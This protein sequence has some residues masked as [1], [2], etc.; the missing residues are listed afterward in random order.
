M[1]LHPNFIFAH[2]P[3]CGGN[4]LNSFFRDNFTECHVTDKNHKGLLDIDINNRKTFFTIRNPFDWYVSWWAFNKTTGIKEISKFYKSVVKDNYENFVRSILNTKEGKTIWFDFETMTKLD[5]GMLTFKFLRI[6]SNRNITFNLKPNEI[7]KDNIK[8]YL[9]ANDY[10]DINKN[11]NCN[12]YKFFKD[13]NLLH[14]TNEQKSLLLK[15][16]KVNTSKHNHYVTYY[17]SNEVIE[18]IK[19][20]DRLIF[21][22]FKYKFGE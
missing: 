9:L 5:I 16:K 19:H 12:L 8:N 2:I 21:E 22:L 20:K 1:I 18:L 11:F 10:I 7:T 3:K 4:F 17:K 6:I 14:F 15:S 13:N